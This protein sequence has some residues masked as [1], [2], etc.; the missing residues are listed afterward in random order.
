MSWRKSV[1]SVHPT[2]CKVCLFLECE[3]GHGLLAAC[4]DYTCFCC[5]LCAGHSSRMWVLY[6][7]VIIIIIVVGIINS[8]P[9]IY[10]L[11][12][13][14]HLDFCSLVPLCFFVH[15]WCWL[16]L[17]LWVFSCFTLKVSFP[18]WSVSW[19]FSPVIDCMFASHPLLCLICNHI[20][21]YTQVPGWAFFAF[22]TPSILQGIDS[23]RW[24]FSPYW[25][26]NITQP[27]E[28][29]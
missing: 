25:H 29:G 7:K 10:F 21:R 4:C 12:P 2:L 11:C 5:V 1:T 8:F 22:R 19:S 16:C 27:S 18:A 15:C 20:I 26:D 17:F 3:K 9:S 14:S 28:V 6:N 23:T 13:L 24:D